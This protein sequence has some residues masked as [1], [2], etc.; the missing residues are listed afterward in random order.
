MG[1][2]ADYDYELHAYEYPRRPNM[3]KT[4]RPTLKTPVFRGSFVTLVK[5]RAMENDDGSE[6]TPK[7]S[8]MIVL[9]KGTPETKKFINDFLAAAKAASAAAHGA[10]IDHKKLKHFPVRDGDSMEG[11]NFKGHYCIR[12]STRFR[13]H[14]VSKDGDDLETEDELY[15]GAWYRVKISLWGWTNKKGGKGVSV[16]LESVLKI[17][18]DKKFGGGS[19]AKEDFADDIDETGGSS[20]DGDDIL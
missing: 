13:P 18:D 6:G 19:N 2:A 11:D 8:I 14:A 4:E 5:P 20:D 7:Y 15:S 17:K 12:A 9:K 16:S 10:A 3:A 1:E